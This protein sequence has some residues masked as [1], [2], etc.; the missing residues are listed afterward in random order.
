ML[1][2]TRGKSIV[3]ENG[4]PGLGVVRQ[5]IEASRGVKN[6]CVN[7]VKLAANMSS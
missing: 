7:M 6:A 2:K 5:E 3:E 4:P 1:S